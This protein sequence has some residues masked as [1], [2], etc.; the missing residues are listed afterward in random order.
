MP[1]W[2]TVRV[3]AKNPQ[4][5]SEKF[6]SSFSQEEIDN[7]ENFTDNGDELT[8]RVD[9]NILIPTP[10]DLNVVKGGAS[11]QD[12]IRYYD[13]QKDK[14]EKQKRLITPILEKTYKEGMTQDEYVQAT[15]PNCMGVNTD[16]FTQV[17]NI[18][19][20]NED[21]I[22]EDI[23]NVLRGFYNTKT[24]GNTDWYEF[25]I[26]K[27]G[28]KWNATTVYVDEENGFAEFQ[29]AW[30]CPFEILEELAKYTDIAVSYADE[31][32]GSNFGAYTI[33]NGVKEDLIKS[34]PYNTLNSKQKVD[35]IATATAL[36]MGEIY[37]LNDEVFGS[38]E[39]TDFVKYFD[40]TR[41]QAQ[42]VG[43]NAV[44]NTQEILSDLGL[45][46]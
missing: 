29:T 14:V 28:T 16:K 13:F 42:E 24:Y 32:L 3:K 34:E 7:E 17:Y 20:T 2:V 30:S 18:P 40:M 5:F 37:D 38:Y 11:Y 1:N 4:I 45:L 43:Q 35:A 8:K 21:E 41:E 26:D 27:W 19:I 39:D 9:F 31:D 22:K 23:S 6:L 15:L 12:E 10:S 46:A 36:T 25:H 33:V 44:E